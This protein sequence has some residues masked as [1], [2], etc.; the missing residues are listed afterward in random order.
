[1][2]LGQRQLDIIN[3]SLISDHQVLVTST[4]T[5]IP[6]MNAVFQQGWPVTIIAPKFFA[7]RKRTRFPPC[8]FRHLM[9][10]QSIVFL[11]TFYQFFTEARL[12]HRMQLFIFALPW[13]TL[14]HVSGHPPSNSLS[15]F[16]W[17]GTPLVNKI[18]RSKMACTNLFSPELCNVCPVMLKAVYSALSEDFIS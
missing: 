5:L 8:W 4:M 10:S 15:I 1:M 13:S 17:Y 12:S 18:L 3:S 16:P 11:K 14:M 6:Q 9:T 2:G 7:I